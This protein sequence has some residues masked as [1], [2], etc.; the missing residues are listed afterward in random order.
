MNIYTA[1]CRYKGVDRIDITVKGSVKP[2]EIL[3]PTW[4]MVKR[5]R[6]GTLSQWDYAVQYFSLIVGRVNALS[7]AW[8]NE[9]D[10]IIMNREQ[11]TLVCFCPSGEFC[12][13]ILAARMIENMGYGKHIGE[14]QI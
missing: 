6:A 9:L 7:P 8:R 5:Y 12:H 13:R 3:A 1:H 4:E 14:W 10:E 2:G 11:I